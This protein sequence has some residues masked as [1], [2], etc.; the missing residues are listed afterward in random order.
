MYTAGALVRQAL[1]HRFAP[2]GRTRRLAVRVSGCC[3]AVALVAVVSVTTRPA[4]TSD[5]PSPPE[6]PAEVNEVIS[7]GGGGSGPFKL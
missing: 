6:A 7:G 2:R 1:D 3:V 4:S 5:R